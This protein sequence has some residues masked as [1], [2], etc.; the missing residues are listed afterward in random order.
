MASRMDLFVGRMVD[1]P[2]LGGPCS[3]HAASGPKEECTEWSTLTVVLQKL[4]LE[5][6]DYQHVLRLIRW[7][8]AGNDLF[9]QG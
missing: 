9:L 6:P 4:G 1:L 7:S 3:L 8:L 2:F 5:G